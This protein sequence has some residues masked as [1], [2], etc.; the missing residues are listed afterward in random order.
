MIQ[1]M[2]DSKVKQIAHSFREISAR[3][4][5]QIFKLTSCT[6]NHPASKGLATTAH[7]QRAFFGNPGGNESS[8]AGEVTPI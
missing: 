4:K 2:E 6:C 1:R 8:V 5:N 3:A 7:P